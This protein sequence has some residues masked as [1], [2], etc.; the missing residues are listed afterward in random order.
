MTTK[1]Q[2]DA[3]AS[4]SEYRGDARA[5]STLLTEINPPPGL[6]LR[7]VTAEDQRFIEAV[8]QSAS[9]Y[10]AFLPLAPAQVELL[11]RQQYQFRQLSFATHFPGAEHWI[12]AHDLH[13]VG[14]LI[15]HETQAGLHI[16]DIALVDQARNQGIGSACLRALKALADARA[17]PL[18]LRVEITNQ[19]AAA[20]YQRLGFLAVEQTASHRLLRW[21]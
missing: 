10:G 17:K 18:S 4:R 19:R 13:P 9:G 14:T 2:L 7:Q 1:S 11:V 16:V 8:F 15:V 12:I 21:H 3:S 20:L 5:S 6:S